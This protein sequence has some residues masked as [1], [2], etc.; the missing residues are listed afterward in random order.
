[1]D[2]HG[3]HHNGIFKLFSFNSFL[4]RKNK[5]ERKKEGKLNELQP[6]GLRLSALNF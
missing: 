5:T 4:K 6:R 3:P 2:L 1:M